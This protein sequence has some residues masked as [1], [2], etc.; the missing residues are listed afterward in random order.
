MWRS[1]LFRFSL[2][3]MRQIVMNTN[4]QHC[5]WTST[6]NDCPYQVLSHVHGDGRHLLV[7][8]A[9]HL[10]N[11]IGQVVVLRLLDHMKQ[12]VHDGPHIGPDVQLSCVGT[13]RQS[14][15]VRDCWLSRRRED[16][17]PEEQRG[18]L[19]TSLVIGG[20]ATKPTTAAFPWRVFAKS[21]RYF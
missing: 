21:K 8:L 19:R 16:N 17:Q 11:D 2:Q 1:M 10:L 3:Q 12:L 7:V 14:T 13:R 5:K 6:L 4:A 15:R 9:D 18:R 20:A